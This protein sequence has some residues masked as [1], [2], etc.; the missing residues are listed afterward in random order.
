MLHTVFAEGLNEPSLPSWITGLEEIREM[1]LG[2]SL[3]DAAQRTGI[4][5][6]SIQKL[7]RDLAGAETAVCYGRMGTCVQAHGTASSWLIDVLNVVTGNLDRP[8]GAMFTRPPAG[9]PWLSRQLD[10]HGPNSRYHSRVSGLP[11]FNG[12]LPMSALAEEI[13]TPGPGQIRALIVIAGNPV[14]SAPDGHRLDEA[15]RGLDLVVA[16]DPYVNETTRHAHYLLPPTLGLEHDHYPLLTEC[17]ALRRSAKYNEAVVPAP[18]DCR[19]DWRIGWDLTRAIA[20]RRGF[21]GRLRALAMGAPITPRRVLGLLLWLGSRTDS[22]RLRLRELQENPHGVDLGPLTPRLPEAL[23]LGHGRVHLAP[24]S[25]I[26]QGRRLL[27]AAS[28]EDA[29]VLSLIGRRDLRSN[30]SWMHNSPR[31]MKGRERCTLQM[32]PA[33]ADA[34]GIT[35]GD[36]AE[37]VTDVATVTAPV[38]LT[39]AVMRGVVSLP[40]GWG[41]GRPGV[42][43]RVA[44][45]SPGVSM[46]DVIGISLRDS[47]SAASQLNGVPV[48]VRRPEP[49][50]PRPE[51]TAA[52]SAPR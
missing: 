2:C 20:K 51:A 9:L 18:P 27:E 32:H 43:L 22:R 33:D 1:A 7:A 36:T 24:A 19:H 3:D 39:E 35:D 12:E 13:L 21:A 30:N 8:G 29:T 26:D 37:I 16:V 46:N 11:E 49:S 47:I 34:R 40:H 48:R 44:G 14:L 28:T 17:F 25:L 42:Q 50:A 45:S 31:L 6:E 5:S 52:V 15:L 10:L 4:P 38:E 23:R 41:H